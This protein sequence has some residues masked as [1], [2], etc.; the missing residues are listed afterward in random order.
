MALIFGGCYLTSANRCLGNHCHVILISFSS[1]VKVVC[2]YRPFVLMS[3]RRNGFCYSTLLFIAATKLS[4][5]Y[6][7]PLS[8]ENGT[9]SYR[10]GVPFT[11]KRFRNRHQMM[12]IL[13]TA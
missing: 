9:K 11:L 13:K 1:V 5:V 12:V 10:F 6:S 4:P 3:V 8:F 2:L 7:I